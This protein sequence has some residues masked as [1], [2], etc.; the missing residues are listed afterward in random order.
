[1]TWLFVLMDI[2]ILVALVILCVVV[3]VLWNKRKKLNKISLS[4]FRN[5][6]IYEK[7][8]EE[9]KKF[10]H[11]EDTLNE[12]EPDE[13]LTENNAE[14]VSDNEISFTAGYGEVT[15]VGVNDEY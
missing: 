15:E 5:E 12:D 13:I 6:E 14:E 3:Y 1:M 11:I 8:A 2:L 10:A 9:Q 4:E 7:S